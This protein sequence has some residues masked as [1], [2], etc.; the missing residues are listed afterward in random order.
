MHPQTA[1]SSICLLSLP[2]HALPF[3]SMQCP[4]QRHL[5]LKNTLQQW[6]LAQAIPAGSPRRFA[7]HLGSL[8]FVQEPEMQEAC[9]IYKPTFGGHVLIDKA[10][11]CMLEVLTT[12]CWRISCK[13]DQLQATVNM[14]SCNNSGRL[15][16]VAASGSFAALSSPGSL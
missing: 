5:T 15:G 8:F 7:M 2:L 10:Q 13:I 3:R 12:K 14:L 1:I 16:I 6:A 4:S 9:I 11:Q